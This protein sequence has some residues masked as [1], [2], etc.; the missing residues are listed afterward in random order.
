MFKPAKPLNVI[1]LVQ[2]KLITLAET[3]DFNYL[4]KWLCQFGHTNEIYLLTNGFRVVWIQIKES[5][6]NLFD[7][8]SDFCDRS[9]YI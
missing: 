2:I 7:V 3:T 6:T 1:T 4:K 8:L 5:N 9:N